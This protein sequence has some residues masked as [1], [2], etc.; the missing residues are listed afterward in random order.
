M[1][2]LKGELESK[3]HTFSES[4]IASSNEGDSTV[5]TWK[6]ICDIKAKSAEEMS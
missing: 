3:G 2:K 6:L 1:G 4:T 5:I